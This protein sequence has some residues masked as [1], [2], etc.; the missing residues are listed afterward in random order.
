MTI[1][2]AWCFLEV[3]D[4]VTEGETQR[5]DEWVIRSMRRSTDSATSLG[6]PWLFEVV[7]DITALGGTTVLVL[8]IGVVSG[9][10][11]IRRAYHSMWLVLT[12][13]LGGLVFSTVLK[14]VFQR[15]RPQLAPRSR[16]PR[17]RAFRAGTH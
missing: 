14:G 7:R 9:Y 4:E 17:F 16:T 15:P 11:W 5:L 12:A 2:S 1:V 3:V 6:P 10:L 13:S 8:V